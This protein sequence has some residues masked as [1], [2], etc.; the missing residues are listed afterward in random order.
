MLTI[1]YNKHHK[2]NQLISSVF[3]VYVSNYILSFE[4]ILMNNLFRLLKMYGSGLFQV[5]KKRYENPKPEPPMVKYRP[6]T[7]ASC[8]PIFVTLVGGILLSIAILI[9]ENIYFHIVQR[10]HDFAHSR[11]NYWR[12]LIRPTHWIYP[13]YCRSNTMRRYYWDFIECTW[14]N[15]GFYVIIY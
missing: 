3:F 11:T 8:K 10:Q 9:C 5:F 6:I 15:S 12:P 7:M 2:I 14:F 4:I 13:A 1:H